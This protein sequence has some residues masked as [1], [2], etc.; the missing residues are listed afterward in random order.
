MLTSQLKLT[1]NIFSP[2]NGYVIVGIVGAVE[3]D[4]LVI[5]VKRPVH[6]PIVIYPV[7]VCAYHEPLFAI[8]L[9]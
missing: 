7:T 2:L 9:T 1:K 8:A 5:I 3:S 4:H 6:R